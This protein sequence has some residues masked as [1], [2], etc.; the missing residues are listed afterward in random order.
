VKRKLTLTVLVLSA[1]FLA[2]WAIEE[3]LFSKLDL[4]PV[5]QQHA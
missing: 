3:G 5:W 1:A 2:A 4:T